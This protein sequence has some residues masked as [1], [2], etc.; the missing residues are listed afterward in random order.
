MKGFVPTPASLVDRMVAKLFSTR[1]P[2][3]ADTV[4][5]PGCGRG[6]FITG[7]LRWCE[8][9]GLIPP[10]IVGVEND[11][12]HWAPVRKRFL[13]NRCVEIRRRDFLEPD[14]D[15]YEFIVG[16]PPYVPIT[17]LSVEERQRYRVAGYWTA[18]GRM[19]LYMLF[20]EAALGRLARG[21]RLVFVT[22]EKF[23]YVETGSS[24]RAL[25]AAK[26]VSEVEL[27]AEDTFP[28]MTTYPAVTT[29]TNRPLKGPT[30]FIQRSGKLS[31]AQLPTD[32]SSWLP[33]SMGFAK[34][35]R[36]PTLD[37]VSLRI[38]P[39]I[40]TGADGVFVVESHSVGAGLAPFAFPTI[41][42]RDL[43]PGSPLP[44]PSHSMLV[45]YSPSGKL[46]TPEEA[47]E[48][49]DYLSD[50]QRSARLHSRTCARRKPWYAFHDS[51]PI[52]EIRRPKLVWKD[53]SEG[54]AFWIDR[55]GSLV[56][57][58][59]VYYLVPKDP[60]K[61]DQIA[62]FLRSEQAASWI[63]AHCQ[64]AANGYLR[65]QSNVLREMPIPPGLVPGGL[66]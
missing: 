17:G 24:L 34:R 11:P 5:D 18:N 39:G 48:L 45:P 6:E 61:L 44:T 15:R 49:F 60:R 28:G 9:H 53:I 20:F 35:A 52:E 56:P 1:L 23:L 55:V 13:G 8:G 25:L 32:G 22:P 46:H 19:D 14:S 33:A 21:G 37:D 38:S 30:R 36:G 2:T 43:K 27:V 31:R 26:D 12:R 29:V 16:N 7:V 59:S 57:R 10:A 41:S 42:G 3:A 65:L 62:S 4:L 54:P 63:R 47:G 64:R 58:H 50:P 66:G 51:A 40:A